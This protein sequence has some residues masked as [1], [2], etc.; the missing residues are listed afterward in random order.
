MRIRYFEK[1]L[2]LAEATKL[3]LF[4]HCRKAADD[5]AR[6]LKQNRDRIAG[7]VVG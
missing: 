5:L 3:P 7:G 4:L 2:E 1:Q 6:I